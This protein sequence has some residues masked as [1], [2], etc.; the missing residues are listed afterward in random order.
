MGRD[1]WSAIEV[2]HG[3]EERETRP[4]LEKYHQVGIALPWVWDRTAWK[5]M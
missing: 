5:F 4:V 2:R 3:S 1:P